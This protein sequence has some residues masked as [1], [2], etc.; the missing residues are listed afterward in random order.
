MPRKSRKRKRIRVLP[1]PVAKGLRDINKITS[2]LARGVDKW[3]MKVVKDVTRVVLKPRSFRGGSYSQ[4]SRSLGGTKFSD[5]AALFK[6]VATKKGGR[7]TRRGGKTR[8]KKTRGG[9]SR[10]GGRR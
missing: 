4:N 2:R 10:K 3:P 6:S 1:R 5:S 7:K 8:G 9:K